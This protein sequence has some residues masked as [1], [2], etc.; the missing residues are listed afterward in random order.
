[1][2]YIPID[3]INLGGIAESK[4][5]GVQNSVAEMVGIDL[6]SEPGSFR[7]N[8]RL[9]K[10][11]GSTVTE[12]CKAIVPCSNGSIYFFSSES[13]KIW[14]KSSTGTYSLVYT[15]TPASGEA[16]CLGAIEFDGY[17]YWA[18]QNRL[19]RIAVGDTDDWSTNASE[20]WACMDQFSS[21][22]GNDNSYYILQDSISHTIDVDVAL[23]N[24]TLYT[25]SSTYT[26]QTSIDDSTQYT[27][28]AK[29]ASGSA[30]FAMVFTVY[31]HREVLEAFV[32]TTTSYKLKGVKVNIVDAGTGNW[33]VTVHDSSDNSVAS[34][35]ISNSSLQDGQYN[36]F[37]FSSP[38]SMTAGEEYHIHITSTVADGTMRTY[39]LSDTS[40]SISG[41]PSSG[42]IGTGAGDV[43]ALLQDTSGEYTNERLT[44][45]AR[46]S[47]ISGVSFYV[48][49]AGSGNWTITVHDEDDTSLGS[50]TVANA[51]ITDNAFNL[52]EFSSSIGLEIGKEY[53]LHITSSV[54]ESGKLASSYYNDLET[55]YIKIHSTGNTSFHPFQIVNG[56]LY[57]ADKNFVHEVS[58][59]GSEH[60]FT[61][62]ALD[63]P[64]HFT[65]K[66]LSKVETD[67]VVGTYIANDPSGS[68]VFRWNTWSTSWSYDDDVRE[69][70]VNCFINADNYLVVSAG[71][72]GNLYF[73]DGTKMWL[74]KTMPGTYSK[75]ATMVVYP[76]AQDNLQGLPLFGVS[77]D[78][79]NPLTEGVY[80]FG[81]GLNGK[82]ILNLEYVVSSGSTSGVDIGAMAV[83][84]TDL[85]VAWKDGSDVGIDKLDWDN[86]YNGAYI[87][88]RVMNPTGFN[89]NKYSRFIVEY[90]ELPT[91]TSIEIYYKENNGSWNQLTTVT[92][93]KRRMVVADQTVVGA[94]L[95]V[96]VVLKT[97]GNSS[98]IIR[99]ILIGVE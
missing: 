2:G 20:D 1:M 98:P 41:Y 10:D 12:L 84:G 75:T 3:N 81:K 54:D 9:T 4:Y 94:D 34:K 63:I 79:G 64:S 19:H 73:Y 66:S 27:Y 53:H 70:G 77:N 97:S 93:T 62:R 91:G 25:T 50:V 89:Q 86:K 38:V 55:G 7:A 99:R 72:R 36:E 82:N 11:S 87:V 69:N 68:Q 24:S 15:T 76:E 5:Q 28:S 51:D 88:S 44:F 52:A 39:E 8:Q 78:S 80:S 74:A 85:Y 21:T 14:E 43:I 17:I 96:K 95:Q 30:T 22:S 29:S 71:K 61:P 92:D 35:T 26:P 47:S 37:D 33:T 40:Y 18:T 6:R 56:N 65:I 59:E 46:T 90:D 49:D 60:V 83:V 32:N 23:R 48:K 31:A 42:A 16:K 57:T 67:L 13:G 45:K 58:A